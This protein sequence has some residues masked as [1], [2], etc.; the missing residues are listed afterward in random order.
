M[1][2]D[3]A[4][5][6]AIGRAVGGTISAPADTGRRAPQALPEAHRRG[7]CGYRRIKPR[8]VRPGRD[9]CGCDSR[10]PGGGVGHALA[11]FAPTRAGSLC[12]QRDRLSGKWRRGAVRQ[13][14]N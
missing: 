4:A 12:D 11:K 9:A 14:L 2:S 13:W 1:E 7:N 3:R 6:S 10:H 8:Q 5:I